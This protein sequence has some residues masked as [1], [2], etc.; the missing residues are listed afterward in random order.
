[1]L[2]DS[3]QRKALVLSLLMVMLAQTAYIESYRGWTLAEATSPSH[4]NAA[5]TS[6][7]RPSG[8]PIHVDAVNGS[9]DW[10][11]TW[12]CPK[13]TL[14]GALNDASASDEIV[15]ASGRYHENVSVN[16]L[17][18]LLIRAADG[19]RVVFDGT[20]SIADDLNVSWSTAD[21][22][23]VQETTLPVDGWQLFLSYDE[24]VPARWPNAQ[25]SDA[26]VFNRSYWAEGTLT[27]SN[28]AYT[29]GWL[30]D[31]GPEA[32]VHT[33]LNETVN[34]TGLDPVG[35]I[36][37]M[38]LGSFRSNSRIIT[39]WNPSNG[40]FAYDGN[41]VGWKNKHHAYFLEGKRE[42]IDQDGEWWFN[43]TNN[44]LHYK[45]PSGQD[46]NDLDLRI[47][48][49]PFAI[50]V[51]N[52]DGVTVQGI[53]FFGTTVNFNECDGCS[54]TNATLEYPSTSKRG[55]GIA[56]ESE[57][58]RWMTRFYRSTNSFV[59]NVSITNTDG[60]AIEF[61][62]SAG[63]SHNN[64]VNNSYFH[65]IDWSAADQKGLM[66]TIYEGGR[67]MYFTNNTVHLTGA[68]SVLSIGD[69]PKVFHNEVW[70]VGHLQTDGAVVQIMQ[71]EAPGAEVAYNWIHDV[72]KYGV[73]FDAPIGQI[74]QGRNGTMHHNVI[75]NAA[76]G[77]MVK[78]D[79]HDIHN[80][81]V[82]NSTASKNDIIALTDGGINNKNSTFH[83]NA[84][85]SMAD[86]RSDD[87]HDHPLPNGTHW[88]NWNG[89]LQGYDDMFEARNQISCAIY[90]NGSLYCWGRNDHGQ[91]GLGYTSGREEVPQY[92]D[93]GTGRTITS[94][95][96]DDSGA[97]GW[98]PNSHSC[99]VLDNGELLCW[100]A[101]GD[102]Q[103]GLGNTSTN[104]VWEPTTVDVGSGL[105]AISVAVGNAATCALLSDHSVK[106][107][108]KNNFGQL[109][110][111]NSSS[112][113][114]L[115]PHAVSF[116]GSS[117]PISLHAGR[118]EFCAQLDNG[119]AACW[120]D[121]AEGQFG[122]GNTTSQTSPISLTL[123]TGRTVASMS[124]SKDFMCLVLDNGSIVCAGRNA[125]HQLG[126]GAPSTRETSWKYVVGLDMV[127]H[128]VE[129]GQD[130]GCAHLING[131]MACWGEDLW[132]LYG[133]STTSYTLRVASTAT[134]YA[135]FGNGR[136][137]ASISLNYR[138][139]C[140]VLDNGDLTC[141]GRN[142]KSQLG[143]GTTTQAFMPMVVSNVSSLRQVAVHEMLV[144]P[145]NDDFRP[146][147]GSQLH[148]LSAGAYDAGDADPWTAGVSWT[149]S[150][151][152]DPVS[153]CMNS[154]AI[155][156]NS[157]AVFEDGSCIYTAL[158]S[159]SSTLSLEVGVAMTP[160]T[161]TYSTPFLEDDKQ[162]AASS[163]AVGEGPN[164]ALDS[165]G[166]V[167]ICSKTVTSDNLYY[168]TNASG[169]WQ[170]ATID[171]TGNV[172]GDCFII[173]DSDDDIHITYRD[174]SN[175][176]LKYATKALSSAIASSNWA[177]STM[178]N[179][180][181]VGNFGSMAVD[182]ND[183]LHVA[184]YS[185]NG[186]SLKYAT[187]ADGSTTWS[188]EVVESTNDV[189][190]YTS[191]AL[192][193]NGN[194]H[195]TYYDDTNN[196][197]RYTHKM[198]SSWTFTTLD[199]TA[200]TGKGTSLAIDS[201][202]HLHVAYKTNSTEI[203]Y[204]TNRSGSWVKTTL[205]ANSTGNW[206]VNYI[207][208]MLDEGD[209]PHVVYSDM[210]DY[211]IF[212]MSNTRGAWERIHVAGDSISKSS[213]AA[214]DENGG[215]HVAYHIDGSFDDVGY[216]AVR[217]LAHRPTYEISPDL[218]QGLSLGAE[219]GTVFGTPMEHLDQTE[220]TVWANTTRTSAFTTFSMNVDWELQA[221]IDWMEVQR[222]TAI[223]PIT[224]NWTAWSSGVVNSTTTV[225]TTGDNG[226][227][228]GIVVDSNDKV[229]IVY[230]R[231]DNA[232]LMYS[233]NASGSWQTTTVE[234]SNNV[235]KYCNL[236][237]DG[238]DGLHISYQYNSGNALKYAYKS[239]SSSGW[240]K[241]TVDNTGG[242]YTSIA[243][244]SNNN[245]HI[246]YRDSGGDVGYATKSSGGSWTYGTVQSAGD[247]AS[248]SI[249]VDA[250]DH[251][252]IAYYDANN[253]DMYHLTNTSGSWAR[254]F[255]EDIGTNT[256]GTALD[257]AID[258]TTDEPGI[259]YFDM[260]ATSLKYTYYTGS[261]WS[262][263][264]VEN[265]ADYG[266]F[267][268]LIYDSTG[269][270]HISHE[271]NSA[272]DLYYTSDKTGSWVS[273]PVDTTNSVG[274]YTSIAVD[275][276]D[277]LH[278]AYRHNSFSRT[279]HATVQGYKIS[280][281]ARTDVSG[282]TCSISP[283]LPF[284]L[285]LNQGTC[286]ISGT[287]TFHGSNITYNVTATSSTGVSK[288]GEFKMWIT[289]IA[290]SITYAG[291]PFTFT[292]GT[293]IS[294]ITPTNTGDSAFWSV[295]PSLPS[296]L[297]LGSGGVISGT[298]SAEA[299]AANY[300]ITASN[301]GGESSAT[302]SITV[303][304]QPPSGLTYTTEN[305]T[306]TQGVAMT[307]NIPSVGGG[308]VSSWE[309]SPD[310]PIGLTFNNTT[311]AITGTPV[312]KQTT[313]KSYTVWA[314][315]SG[316][317]T[318]ASLNIT[319]N[320][321]APSGLSF[322]PE[323]MT[324]TKGVAMAAN[325]PSVS[326]GT[327]TSWAFSPALPTGLTYSPSNGG[328]T[329]TPSVL[330]TTAVTYT[331]WANNSGGSTSATVNITINDVPPNTIVYS[332]HDLTLEKGTAMTTIT[333]VIGGGNVT[334]WA[335]SPSIPNGLSFSS[336]TGAIS[337][338]PSVL[339]TSSVTYTIW[340]NNSGGSASTQVNI[341]INDQ[342]ASVSYPS[343]VEVSNDRTMTTVTPT[344]SGGDVV[345][346]VIVPSLPSGLF[347]GS[348]NGSL[349][350]T[351]SGLLANA[352]YTVFANNSG[353]STSV[354][355][356][357]GL[358]WTLTPS[359]EGAY[360]IR[361]ASIGADI[362]WEWDYDSLEASN[363]SVVTGEYNTCAIKDNGDVY[364]WGRNGNGQI[365]NG[366][367]S[368][369]NIA[370]GQAG[371]QCKDV[372]TLTRVKGANGYDAAGLAFGDRHACALLD[373]GA[374]VCWGRNNAGQLGTS[375]GDKD[376]PQSIN[377]GT[378]RT[379]TSI[380]AG[381]NYNCAILDDASVK[382]W[383]QND[384][385]QLGRGFTSSSENTP[386]TI[387]SLGSGRTAVA[388]A[389][390]FS[391]VCALLDDGSV[392]CWGDDSDGQLGNGGSDTDISSPP[393]S[394]INLGSGRTAKAITGG[395]AHF[396]AV[397]DDD[398]IVCWGDGSNGKLGTASATDQRTPTSTT[399]SFASGRYAVAIDAGY[400]H[401][402]AILDNGDLT[403]WGSDADGQL[404]NGATTGTKYSLQS[405]VVNLGS[406][407]TAISLSAGGKHTC[408][409]LDNHQLMC[410]GHRGSGQVGD[411]G[412]YN[413]P[414]DRVSPVSVNGGHAYL[415]TGV[416]PSPL[417]SGA[418]CSIS[419]SLP[420]GLSLT[421][422]TCTIT[423]TPTVTATNA[424]YT[425]WANVS[426]QSFSGQIWL[427]VGLN[428]P[429]LSYIPAVYTYTK[430]TTIS[431]VAPINTGGEVTSWAINA[432]LPSGL[433]FG[434]S[435]GSI[436][437]TPDTVTPTTTYTVYA[438]NSAGSSSTTITFTVNDPAP[439]FYYGGASGG[440]YHPVVLYLNQTMNALHPTMV[441]GSGAPTSCSS[442][443][444]L[445]SGITLSSSCVISGTPNATNS[446]VFYTIT[447]TNTGG[448][449]MGSVY[450][451]IRSYGGALT[452]SPTN[453]EGAVNTT[454]ANITMSYTHSISNYGWTSGVSNT[455]TTLTSGLI[456]GSGNHWLGVDS[457]EQGEMAVVF[458]HNDTG[459]S[460]HSLALMYRWNG[461]WTETVLDNGT[462]TGQHPSVAIDRQGA[463]HIA[464]IDDHNDKLR[465]ATNASG[466]WVF[467]TLG[468]S[469]YDN[470]GGRG[471]AIVVHPITDAVHIVT[472][473]YENSS[474]DLQYHTNE[475]G[476]W[477]NETITN[478]SKD[479]GH[480]PSMVMD[481]DGNLYVAHYCDN[482][483]SDLRMS[484]R[485]NGV[486]QNETVAGVANM[487]GM[488]GNYNIGTTPE[489]AID[490]QGTLHIVSQRLNS[491]NIY[492]HSGTPGNWYENRNLTGTGAH[493]PA[494]AVDSNDAVHI[495][496]HVG[497]NKD[498]MYLTNAS[499]SWP[500]PASI[501]GYGGWGSVMHIDA[502]DDVF[503]PN[504]APGL[505][506]LQ[507]TTV[508]G[509]GQGLT[510]R[511]IY[512]VSPMLPDGLT[513]NWR[514]G[515]ISGTPTETHTNTTHTVTV[516][517]LGAT[518]T[519][520][521][522]LLVTGV[523]GDVS[524]ANITGTKGSPIVP[525][526]PSFSNGSTSGS[527]S[528]W[529]I[530]AT[531]PG[532]LSFDTSTG[533]ISGT[534]TVVVAGAVFTV[535]A[536]NSAGSTSTTVNITVNDVAVSSFTY[537]A[538]N[539]TLTL[540][541]T[542]TTITATTTG[543][544]PT[545]W[546]IH[547]AL[548]SG[549]TFNAATGAISGTPE[550]LQTTTVTYTVWANNSGGSFSDQINITVND[551]PPVPL[552]HFGGNI[553]LNFNQ[554]MTPLGGFE[555]KPD[556]LSAGEDHTCA[557]RDDGR[558]LCWGEGDYGKLGI[559]NTNDKSSPQFTNSLGTGRKAI[560][561]S[562]GGEHTCAV[563]DNGSV[564]CWGRDNY[565]QIGDG[566]SGGQRVS[567]THTVGLP[568]PAVAVEVGMDFSCA[569]LDN[570]S[571]MC[572]GRGSGG[573]LGNGGTSNSAQPVY[574]DP[575]PGGRKAVAIDI[576]HYHTCAVLD[577]GNVAC[578]GSGGGGR[579][580]TG[581]NSG[582]SS[583]T[584][585][586]YFSS[587]N[588]AVDVALGR[589][590]GC[591]L[592]ANGNVTCWGEGY[593]G[594]GNGETTKMSPGLAWVNLPTGRTAVSVEM[595]RKHACMQ[596]DN[597]VVK[598]WGDDQY[599]Q[600]ANGNGENDRNNPTTV[601][602]ASGIEAVSIHAGHW[603]N[604]ITAQTNEVYCW[605]DGK[606][607]KLGDGGT[608]QH[609]FAGA[610]AKT[611]HFSGSKPVLNHGSITSW[612]VHPA[613]PAGLSLGSTNGTLWGAPT[614]S[615]PQTN[616]TVYGNNSGGSSSFVLN[617]GVNLEA[618][619][620]FQ[621]IP[622][623][624]TLTN[625]T[626]VY[627]VPQFLNQTTGNGST[628]QAADI[629]S[630]A[631][632][633][634]VP[635]A[636]MA[637]L[638][639][640]TMYFDAD[641]G[642]AGT[643]RELWAYDISNDS[644]WLVAN[645]NS[646]SYSNS[647]PGQFMSVLVGDTIYF[648]ANDGSTGRELWAHDTS[649]HSTWRVTNINSS[650]SSD[651][652]THMHVLVGDTIY[653]NAR[654][655]YDSASTGTELWA[656]DTSNHST[657][658]VA[659]INSGATSSSPGVNM[660]FLIGDTLYFDASGG[661]T[662]SNR[663][664]WAHDTSN[665][666]TWQVADI[667]TGGNGN[668]GLYMSTLVGDT[669]YFSASD[670]STG[671][672]LWAHD[673]SNHSTWQ[674][675]NI[676]FGLG[677]S[678]P[679]QHLELLVGDT[680]YFSANDG[681]KGTELWAHDTSNHST[682]RV[683]DINNWVMMGGA[684]LSSNPGEYMAI[685]VGD[686]IY[687]SA[688]DQPSGHELWAHDTSNHSTWQVADIRSGPG[689]GS[690]P[691]QYMEILIGDTLYFSA[692]DGSTGYELWAHDTSNRSTWQVDDLRS[693][694]GSSDPG[695]NLELLVGDTLYFAANDG[696]TG[697]ELWAH[698]PL[699]IDYNT[700]TG[701]NVTTWAINA[702]LPSGVSFGTNN[703]T[704]YGTPT[705]LW[706]QTS[707]MVWANNSGGSS[708]AY[709]NITVVD[710]LPTLSYSP[711][712]LVLIKDN[713]S[714]DLP[715][716]ATLTGPGTITSW[717]INATLPSGLNF[718]TSNGTVWGI[719]TVLQ[720]TAAAY[721]IWANNSG[722]S[723]VAYLNITV[724]D[725]LA[726]IAY[727]PSS[728][729]IVRGYTMA[730]VSAT[731]TGGAVVSWTISPALPS[732]LSFDNG[733]VH[734]RPMVNMSA[735]TYTVYAN[736]SGG[737]ATATLTLT[738][739]EPTPNIDYS[740][741][742][743]TMTNGTSY[744]ITPT[745]LGQTGNISS[746]LGAGTVSASGA[747]TYGNLLI[748]RTNDWRMWA[749]NTS[750]SAST[751]NP[752]V[753]ATNVSFTSCTHHV[754]HNGTMYFQ[755]STNSTGAELWKTD[756]TAA[757]TSMVKDI[758]SGTSSS[759][760]S[761][762]FV[763]NDEV[764]FSS[765]LTSSG[766]E[767]WKTNGTSSGT[768]RAHA[769]SGCYVS[770]CNFHSVI[771]YNGSF[772]GG[773][774]WNQNGREVL[775][776][777]SSGLSLLV[778]LTP[779]QRFSIPRMTNP[780]AFLVH[781]GWL[782][783]LTNGN[784]QSGNGNCLYRS[785]GT[786]A[787]TTPFVCDTSS[788]GLE[789]FNDELYFSRSANYKG[790]ELWKTDGTAAGTVMVK[791]IYTGT[792]S[793]LVSLLTSTEDFL[794]FSARTGTANTDT[795]LW[796][797]DGTNAG[798]QLVKSGFV[799]YP[800]SATRAVI[801]DVLYL[802]GTQYFSNSDSIPGL[803]S[804]D[805]TTN[806]T[807]LY[808][809]YDGQFPNP[810][811]GDVH[812]INGS[813]YFRYYNGTA[814]TYGQM[815]NAAGAIIG[816]PSNW[817]ISPSLPSGLNFGTNNGTIWGTPTALSTTTWYNI[818]ATN[819]NG[820]STTSINITINDQ[821]PSLSYTPE[822][823]TLTIGQS[824]TDLPLNA[825]LTGSGEITS[826][827]INAT[828]PAGLNFGTS[829]G[830]IWGVPTVLQTTAT[831]YTVW[832]NNSGGST[833]ATINITINDEAPGPFEYIP[834]N[835]IWT[836]NSYVNIGPS[837]INITTGNGSSWQ[838]N[839]LDPTK[840]A[841]F[842][843]DVVYINGPKPAMCNCQFGPLT[844]LNT[845]NGTSWQVLFTADNGERMSFLLGDVIYFDAFG[846]NGTEL[847][848]YNTSNNT[849]WMV[850]DINNGSHSNPGEYLSVLVGDT[851]YFSADD[852]STGVE[853]WA[854]NTTNGTTWQVADIWSGTDS[855]LTPPSI[856]TNKPLAHL[857]GDTVYF[858]ANDG[859]D[860]TE[861]W[862]HNTS[863]LT[864]WQ[865][866]DI[867]PYSSNPGS[868]SSIH[869]GDTIYF[870]ADDYTRGNELW[871]HNASNHTT[872]LVSDINP[873]NYNQAKHSYPGV[874]MPFML[875]GEA[876][877]FSADG[878]YGT[879]FE[880]YAHN[881]SNHSTW[882]VADIFQDYSYSSRNSS[883]PGD[884][885]AVLIGDTLYFDARDDTT[886]LSQLWAHDTSNRTTWK[887]HDASAQGGSMSAFGARLVMVLGDTLYF[888]A[889]LDTAYGVEM[890]AHDT[891]NQ[892]TWL[893]SDQ[894]P[895]HS[896]PGYAGTQF[897]HNGT[898]YFSTLTSAGH[899]L[900]AHSP[901]SIN[902]QT[903]TGGAVTSWAINGS[904]PSGV[905]FN[906]QTGV[907]SGTP[908]E[909]WPQTT[910]TVWANNSG[911]SSTAYL[912][913]TVV[914][915]LPTIAYS[916]SN[917]L[918]TNNTPST[919]L[920][921]VPTLTGAGEI[922]SWAI[923]ASLPAGLTFETSNGTIWGTPTELWNTTAYVVWANNSGGSSVAYLNITVIDQLP[924][925]LT[926]TPENLTMV[927]DEASTDLPLVPAL[928]GPGEITSWA[929]NGSLPSGLSFGTTNG[930]IWG[931]PLVNMTTT[932]YTVWANNTGGSLSTTINVTVLEPAVVLDYNPENMTLIRGVQ[933]A[934][935]F[936]S[937]SGGNA[938]SWTISPDL[939]AGLNF[940]DGVISGTPT[941]NMTLSTFTVWANTSGGAASHTVNITILEPSGNLSYSPE[942]ITL[943][944]GV[945]MSNLHPTYSGGV[946]ENW[947]IHPALPAGLNFSNGVLS[948]TSS[949]NMT[950]TMFTV[951]AN[952]SGGSAAATI[953]ITVL[954]PV[955]DLLYSPDNLTL[956][957]GTTMAPLHP[958]VSG[959]NVSEWGIEPALPSGLNFADG[960]FSGTPDVNMTQTQFTVYANT[961]G[962]SAMAWVNIT[963]LEP[964]V[965]LSYNPYNLTLT[966]N[967][968]MTPLS[969]TVSGG[970]VE[971]WTIVPALPLGLN[972]SN[973]VIS[974]TPEVNMTTTMFTVWAN[975]SGGA[976]STTVNITVLEP[977]VDFLYAPNSVVMTRGE[978]ADSVAPVF[979]NDGVAE[980][981]TISPALPAGLNF[982]NGAI[983]G[984][985][986]VNM[987]A[988]VFT[989]YA[990]N[991]GG[992]AAAYL[993]ITVL[994]PV[995]IVAYVPE[996]ITLTRGESN[997]TIVPLLGGGMVE[998]WSITPALPD[999]L[1000]FDNG[1001][1002][1003]GVPLVN[1004]TTITYIVSAQNTGGMA[1005]AYLNLT[1006][1007]EPIA[1008]LSLNHS[1009]LLTRGETYLNATVNNTGGQV[1010]S[1011]S[1012]EPALPAGV[1013]L[1014][1015]GI[1016]YG[1017]SEVNLTLTTFTLWAN[1018]SGGSANLTFTLEV[1019]EP[1020]SI[1021]NYVDAE[1022]VLVNGV[1023]RG[1024]IIPLVDGG[1025]PENWSIEPAL[1026]PGLSFV[1027][1028]YIV[1029]VATTNLTTTSYT[1030]W[1031]NNSGGVALATFN[1032]TV[1033]QPTFY[1034]RYPVTRVVLDVNETMPT[1035]SPIYYFGDNQNPTWSIAP[1036]LPEGLVFENGKVSGT[1037]LEVSNET[1038]YTITV[1039][1040]EMVPV[1041][1042][1043]VVIEVREVVVNITVESVRNSTQIEQFIL[1044][1045]IEEVDDSFDMYWIC[1046]PALLLIVF[1047][1048]VAAIN[1049]FL[1050]LTSKE[1051]DEDEDEN[1052][1053]LD[1054]ED[1055]DEG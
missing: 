403:C 68:S 296:G 633:S 1009:F 200:H 660:A 135:N 790:Y 315:N 502:N 732:G 707:Y 209:D 971:V 52:S 211:D 276:N 571:V 334:L 579:L 898:M 970:D 918:L 715:L 1036:E 221:S 541:H 452:V 118:N 145:A 538:E 336:T 228:N 496:Y 837:F 987:T 659:D 281:D 7:S 368:P 56:G 327:V 855:G 286:T 17:D 895:V 1027:D 630:G 369:I 235:G 255:L 758:V 869:I 788:L 137:A 430:G 234:S 665:H 718:G 34:A 959:G 6:T 78:G 600:M 225:A 125:E 542:M 31:A 326:G 119:S 76:G 142:H 868:A 726:N 784:P 122:L 990:N 856:Y 1007:V 40:T 582:E 667:S 587:T 786:A 735:T 494:V 978:A 976:A 64:T 860:G 939:P 283:S 93:L 15:L 807:T 508:K 110:L 537:T 607:G 547:P 725:E 573:R 808:T 805:G 885:M 203:A 61:Q 190:K 39:D 1040:G 449:D 864:T 313:A 256:G 130:V 545:S 328:I 578:W 570:G 183:T 262:A 731:N 734:G 658:R 426:G 51:E 584:L 979:G 802:R 271:R 446:G 757:G 70:D 703:G 585:A 1039:Y 1033:N 836:N 514:T 553:T 197:L 727:N 926:Y 285:A 60:G 223:T 287:P 87:V 829:N 80:N 46:A 63:Q 86:H 891:S 625:N 1:M 151:M 1013:N 10:N 1055:E 375:G 806:G 604:C 752:Y 968:S 922:T 470:D 991:S 244:D 555:L 347:F 738:I 139:A 420:T 760:P 629:A 479:E 619:G 20:Q 772:Y 701:G 641:G 833:S 517:A 684:G 239:A 363:L 785:N 158:S 981:W 653:F 821:L 721:T 749:F 779:G 5:C 886:G 439:N 299:S 559:G 311:G 19:A 755:A 490:S 780:S 642:A 55:L 147:W 620:P 248:T 958:T 304:V 1054:D 48:V 292:V 637:I 376:T 268:S 702:S 305:M 126:Q 138:H 346:W 246:A 82:F 954:E 213:E 425:V 712:S 876:F 794:Y 133:N 245:P 184:Y 500:S 781:D 38:N 18:N 153:G 690:F 955:V 1044:P 381:G 858:A 632:L 539:S 491:K 744:T 700:N 214:M 412:G 880:L 355:F 966:R 263:T 764:H 964:A 437:G 795:G 934:T 540:Y 385:G 980:A 202:D 178:D 875:T 312:S 606:A 111:G 562:A 269:N 220:F 434:T 427:E 117:N 436:W 982:S 938:S 740:P 390:A 81:T 351:P 628:W 290:P 103:L 293:P 345:S 236:A 878:N 1041:E 217:S 708:V 1051:K 617:L 1023:S 30:T 948:G 493:W 295:S 866:A 201:N 810:N 13:A 963:V 644:A 131:S 1010:A 1029:G 303:N 923:N 854:H 706:T 913:I 751:S 834:E 167:H 647:W 622:E 1050:A 194:P 669:L 967:V 853:L 462:D 331:V 272:D 671:T 949:I 899:K 816:Q 399:G 47:K 572:W 919:D 97:E 674:A 489:M 714:T 877:Y 109:G 933:M 569:L 429:I 478:T 586:N 720:T 222:N 747:C 1034:A 597:G 776:Y 874:Y 468:V 112:N 59:D 789:L 975:T 616:F 251:I 8:S 849:G 186:A 204:M 96:I 99:A 1015:H 618:P 415:D 593:L 912:N 649:N 372:P 450:I 984:T 343:T 216:A 1016:L 678:M 314:N 337:G 115:T 610:A 338:T 506:L 693:G 476:S 937:V 588:Q 461:A 471:T 322:S 294:S 558:V 453:R 405:T 867:S 682:W 800:T 378:G 773:G 668:V 530:N 589:Y 838:I 432:T 499:G 516:T 528:S 956:M 173:L 159:S 274:T 275:S 127:A 1003:T 698:R 574:T 640:N 169:S 830:T 102:G 753:L 11:G 393:S 823:L 904:L 410:W 969:P 205:D 974:G 442:S 172:G 989:I 590:T 380:H 85:D 621:Y 161:L 1049:N 548:P 356:T 861:L 848:A 750:L 1042:L 341:T 156:S 42:L 297:S 870:N 423:G 711:N 288:S 370:C 219:N 143:L 207:N 624:N 532:G 12:S 1028:G 389:T 902:H 717:E 54:F 366:Q 929:I 284:G 656:H 252:H 679:G 492:L 401:T 1038:N 535:W 481:G 382:C 652:G 551:H 748:F 120:G 768:V 157:N 631:G 994:E 69:A 196:D 560:D 1035:L 409:Q 243:T 1018:N 957:R 908:T 325:M 907:L 605:G 681:S 398:S 503:I 302:V 754:V 777:N 360:I 520:T 832:A 596:L 37:V 692:D 873:A 719:P 21:A 824:S 872:W 661:G 591:A 171:S 770:N 396:C 699:S 495:T 522:T 282:A 745:L 308:T 189:G 32:G 1000:I 527:V 666:S 554:T 1025:V 580:G 230:Y 999:G 611:N 613:L 291:S 83:R 775:M 149:Y 320:D 23:G 114:V 594:D 737:S 342:V 697:Y 44:R 79:Y 238:N 459:A 845:S 1032:L 488:S 844:A 101:N 1043:Y 951:Y 791:D 909:L 921:L 680:L 857:I 561:I 716:N 563:L 466:S 897:Y 723:S 144:D 457:G 319:V 166:A 924:T 445:P 534:P 651:V 782:W 636:K 124:A 863:N 977:T 177:V 914:D 224:F 74:G 615:I 947:S 638:V 892:S 804:T 549:L 729:T 36:A 113:D 696:S 811:V 418:T 767:I 552:N 859:N 402:C 583:P 709:L 515:T 333:P 258:P 634:S 395:E 973:G 942:N 73:R 475:G 192:D 746:I 778:D 742:N 1045:E 198:G 645:I 603:H 309:I 397:L 688:Q 454:L 484:S 383:G 88:S 259:S 185:G 66:T 664:L 279:M 766:V 1001:S 148:Q 443:P 523:P 301:P 797:T 827:E 728:V 595:G 903:N 813:L 43:N 448:S 477:V 1005:Y 915:Q 483:C 441:S 917:L 672:E 511:P 215:I 472:T 705:E 253:K 944:R 140:A 176:N 626:E 952:N 175:N 512:D 482:G 993:T 839:Q 787:G 842:V 498:M 501:Y 270:V 463:L 469:S 106:C 374:V 206:G 300:T 946:V 670:G 519:A 996:N 208:I 543:G 67:D 850:S 371:H 77:L 310:L 598:C 1006:V 961:S 577:D 467:L 411:G 756:G 428:A 170:S 416:L 387:N 340:A 226:N 218:P 509:S 1031:A 45:T 635:G 92:V 241:T 155:N 266:R 41:G 90:E 602:F 894:H 882:L 687:F 365:G 329:G 1026:P 581:S 801:G 386:A 1047:L 350:G 887:V 662:T 324:L 567:P 905:S 983:T 187:L 910:Y 722:G 890:W 841:V 72:I 1052:D 422:G 22:D 388:L 544:T 162:T 332:A 191:I 819:A 480:D 521:F 28:N 121:N 655:G 564:M 4:L 675:A 154:L 741:D 180:G 321:V 879:G 972:F 1019:I 100:G 404:G 486:W 601:N 799:G 182:A 379:A 278:I 318:S 71:G 862:A 174:D 75:W 129:L 413:N 128:T 438:N 464:Y 84:V 242:K 614:A 433:S 164:I 935:L 353:G 447:G 783:F 1020:V 851:I 724:V 763:F 247:I 950:T 95:G 518:T 33:G 417:V 639:G 818:T 536:N 599:G 229:H 265:S 906:T 181:N 739:N 407:R 1037:A 911:G 812:N 643:G 650:A 317:S 504:N 513:M 884:N 458:A 623:N 406:G 531:P 146:T 165:N 871:A 50:S 704:I 809:N 998:T 1002:I 227:Y 529:A 132:G 986:E 267:N 771:E 16:N 769:Y 765:R 58:D 91:L 1046:F 677:S 9:D 736:N 473:I 400:Q 533:V 108:G 822:N 743:Y 505:G 609:N 277:D 565:G 306:L 901:L 524:Y 1004:S 557:I 24:Q 988:T 900:W 367:I 820:S 359:V 1022:I 210:V 384:E 35:A 364:C 497:T 673:T 648:D 455:T 94:L 254:T 730:N 408:A 825:T 107:W 695:Q 260:D 65:A 105:T 289:P 431:T 323:N 847:W 392:K 646:G 199:S 231:D 330:Q 941:V 817:S 550:V 152:S 377:L 792:N 339:Q 362:T 1011:W 104:G 828:L 997:A 846:N 419:P 57:D 960:V 344:V 1024:R 435:N 761:S 889:N 627:L 348:G 928:T 168:T 25:F 316:G 123:P 394:A 487:H 250:D 608:T 733:T 657:W 546:G 831:T 237:I 49:Q 930:T 612:T 568:R 774:H 852:G 510:V 460:T 89:Y 1048:I 920:P 116:S 893:V 835:N 485:I 1017:T 14:S 240:T 474:R 354:A 1008:V 815:N 98:A 896:F 349:W 556:V 992:S 414:S 759:S 358:N 280:S 188:R 796:R 576:S 575:M 686:T 179:N 526:S 691:G 883:L 424:T 264:T 888:R 273:T 713:Q 160:H 881:V 62:G 307:A 694:P 762:F 676:N 261:A 685:S 53:D 136:S 232:N 566:T 710:E 27:G 925:S 298:P 451:L 931:V 840:L 1030:V 26:T 3:Q 150:P 843:G 932:T 793:G 212:Y 134:Q 927:R 803:W 141:W 391:T 962:G 1012:I 689:S 440:G 945:A 163:G 943:T 249:A 2:N 965:N 233:T 953:N 373:D 357:L 195:I 936:P 916:A 995:A 335:I 421:G 361:N 456:Y 444:S 985:P 1014:W 507:M 683:A 1021:L 663:E 654:D 940:S 465:Y 257:I 29:Q 592:M 1053:E 352:T 865:V 826:W 193:S 525:V 798:T 814:S